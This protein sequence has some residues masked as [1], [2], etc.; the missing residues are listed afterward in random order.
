MAASKIFQTK[1]LS[2]Q[3]RFLDPGD[4]VFFALRE[5][6]EFDRGMRSL[7]AIADKLNIGITQTSVRA[8]SGKFSDTTVDNMIKVTRID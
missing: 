3:L 7:T 6:V 1:K 8:I 2:E 4:F 5:G